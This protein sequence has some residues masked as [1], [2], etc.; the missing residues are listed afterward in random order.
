MVG[1]SPRG[2][3]AKSAL[4]RQQ[5]IDQALDVFNELGS[6][7]TSLRS[8]ADALGVTHPVL[9]HHFGSRERLFLEVLRQADARGRE[10]LAGEGEGERSA[11]GFAAAIAHVV[12]GQPGL[13]PLYVTMIA[14]A[15]ERENADS[16]PFFA[17]R[18][19]DMRSEVVAILRE[20]QASGLVRDD[21]AVESAAAVIVAIS[22]GLSTQW[23]IDPEVD[24]SE[25]MRLVDQLL[26]PPPPRDA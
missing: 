23:L 3:Y 8:I 13:M 6:D 7:R 15:L 11:A 24:F 16:R 10:R 12:M 21:I 1:G 9:R 25:A 18:F 2:P 22:D 4:R 19:R 20:G 17:E 5:I 26:A 14:R